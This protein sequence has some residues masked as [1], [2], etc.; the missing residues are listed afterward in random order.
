MA[1]R[2]HFPLDLK[3]GKKTNAITEIS[4]KNCEMDW[5]SRLYHTISQIV[6]VRRICCPIVKTKYRRRKG[7]MKTIWRE[8]LMASG[9]DL[10]GEENLLA[11]KARQGFVVVL[12]LFAVVLQLFEVVCSCLQLVCRCLPLFAG[13]QRVA[14]GFSGP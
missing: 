2:T 4:N 3:F 12:R 6:N 7:G 5:K 9:E 10:H 1:E 13:W 8:Q 11:K 14:A